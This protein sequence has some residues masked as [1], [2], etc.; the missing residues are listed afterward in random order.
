M[1][2]HCP[3]IGNCV[4]AANL[5]S[6]LLMLAWMLLACMYIFVLG[7]MALLRRL[8]E[9]GNQ[10]HATWHITGQPMSSVWWYLSFSMRVL[11]GSPNWLMVVAYLLTVAVGGG[12][13]LS[14]LLSFQVGGG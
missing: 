6:F 10:F 4:G 9:V 5:R 13:G 2:H 1:D 14:M 7:V 3:F 11:V 12:I 8:P